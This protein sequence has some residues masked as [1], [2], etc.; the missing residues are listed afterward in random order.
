MEVVGTGEAMTYHEQPE[1]KIAKMPEYKWEVE[2]LPNVFYQ[3]EERLCWWKR[4]WFKI[5]F[6]WT[7]KEYS[8]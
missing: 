2:V 1:I 5:F 4:M 8:S 7:W 6:G 3:F